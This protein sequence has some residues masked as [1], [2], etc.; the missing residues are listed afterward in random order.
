[1]PKKYD[2]C[3]RKIKAKIRKGEIP[4]TY[5][6]GKKRLKTSPYGICKGSMTGKQ[7]NKKYWGEPNWG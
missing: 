3:I 6:K 5:K 1:M 7:F 4:R 2:R